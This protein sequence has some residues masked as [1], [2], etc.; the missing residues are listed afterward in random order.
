MTGGVE[1]ARGGGLLLTGADTAERLDHA[2]QTEPR[3]V[4]RGVGVEDLLRVG[5][6]LDGAERGVEGRN[7]GVVLVV[8][9]GDLR[10]TVRLQLLDDIDIDSL[11]ESLHPVQITCVT[12]GLHAAQEGIDLPEI[13][14]CSHRC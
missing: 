2:F 12:L 8:R 9:R 5:T 14:F 6:L 1:P 11:L 10:R 3:I 4:A 13:S 7:G